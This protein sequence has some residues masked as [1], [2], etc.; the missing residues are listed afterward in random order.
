MLRTIANIV[1]KYDKSPNCATAAA[2]QFVLTKLNIDDI[3]ILGHS[4][5]AGIAALC[6]LG[7][8]KPQNNVESWL[9][10]IRNEKQESLLQYP[11]MIKSDIDKK[12]LNTALQSRENLQSYPWVAAAVKQQS[13]SCMPGL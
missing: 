13:Y 4:C 5:C 6:N 11:K 12:A 1:P 3:I 8:K 9:A 2:L 10:Q 7:N